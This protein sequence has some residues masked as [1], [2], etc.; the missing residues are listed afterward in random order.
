MTKGVWP[1]DCYCIQNWHLGWVIP[2]GPIR[3]SQPTSI[4]FLFYFIIIFF[5]VRVREHV[6]ICVDIPRFCCGIEL[7]YFSINKLTFFFFLGYT[8]F[9]KFSKF[10]KV[11]SITI[12]VM[13]FSLILFYFWA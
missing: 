12:K 4:A 9:I 7:F 5:N 13:Y 1:N 10:S 8:R 3:V 6:C 11:P 2:P